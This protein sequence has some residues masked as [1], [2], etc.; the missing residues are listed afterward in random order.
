MRA[1]GRRPKA[2]VVGVLGS[3]ALVLVAAMLARWPAL[4]VFG[5]LYPIS[6][7]DRRG[8]FGCGLAGV[9]LLMA[10]LLVCYA[11]AL[12]GLGGGGV[13]WSTGE[14]VSL[15]L[16]LTFVGLQALFAYGAWRYSRAA[17]NDRADGG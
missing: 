2:F 16:L 17:S 7:L 10:V 12:V 15:L 3:A 11:G 8:D 6:F 5:L 13:G 1:R 9:G 4:A 14:K